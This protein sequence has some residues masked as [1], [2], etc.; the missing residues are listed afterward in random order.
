MAYCRW[1]SDDHQC[2]V[3]TYADGAGVWVTHVAGNRYA[4]TEPLPE[5]IELPHLFTN[6]QFKAWWDRG[7]EVARIID[8]S[9]LVAIGLPHDG[10]R[11][12]DPTPGAAADTLT[13]LRDAGYHVP[14]YAIDQLRKEAVGTT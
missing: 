12:N 3:Y 7:S 8:A 14:Q 2:D 1:S 11:F 13:M 6:E 5:P 10:E 9:E 4:V